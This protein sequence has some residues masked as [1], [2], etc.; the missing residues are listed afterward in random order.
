VQNG[1]RIDV[2]TIIDVAQISVYGATRKRRTH[3]PGS[4]YIKICNPIKLT[5][6]LRHDH[7]KKT[8]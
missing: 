7:P 8:I 3:D 4:I 6:P 1:G 2:V 5:I